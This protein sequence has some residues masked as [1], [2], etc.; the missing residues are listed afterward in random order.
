MPFNIITTPV[1]HSSDAAFRVW[2]QEIDAAFVA[3]GWVNT[4]DTGQVNLSTMVRPAI[5]TMA[6]YRTYYY[7][8]ALH[9]SAPIYLK[10]EFGTN[11]VATTPGWFVSMGQGTNGAGSLIGLTSDR[12]NCTINA[13]PLS[14]VTNYSSYVTWGEG[15]FAIAWKSGASNS[16]QGLFILN[17]FTDSLGTPVG[18]GYAWYARGTTNNTL[19]QSVSYL[20]NTAY[21]QSAYYCMVGWNV[22]NSLVGGVA[23]TY[24]NYLIT[25][26]MQLN[27]LTLCIVKTELP[28]GNII[29]ADVIGTGL[30][31]WMPIGT[32]TSGVTVAQTNTF[33]FA[34]P[35]WS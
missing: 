29:Q 32:V 11:N 20:T 15:Y 5:N 25:P 13:A 34:I 10:L 27:P 33:G 28:T 18:D 16:G 26:R 22:S 24:R 14:T 21:P 2:A 9:A 31:D 7:N 12:V 35:W 8:D 3:A 23:Q 17:R 30:R 4:A 1:D 6:G 19:C